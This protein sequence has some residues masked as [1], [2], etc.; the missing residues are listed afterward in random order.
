MQRGL[1][2]GVVVVLIGLCVGAQAAFAAQLHVR[3]DG[4]DSACAGTLDAAAQGASGNACAFRTIQKAV[5]TLSGPGDRVT[6]HAGSYPEYVQIG[7]SHPNG[8]EQAPIVIEGDPNVP[9]SDVV[10]DGSGFDGAMLVNGSGGG[11]TKIYYVFQHFSFK[12]GRLQGIEIGTFVAGYAALCVIRDIEVHS[13]NFVQSTPYNSRV[14]TA[15]TWANGPYGGTGNMLVENVIVDNANNGGAIAPGVG[16]FMTANDSILRNTDIR[17]LRGLGRMGSGATVEFNRMVF[18]DCHSDD[19]CVQLYNTSG[20]VFRYNTI[21]VTGNLWIPNYRFIGIRGINNPYASAV[22]EDNVFEYQGT[23][24]PAFAIVLDQGTQYA[25]IK[26]NVFIGFNNQATSGV[27]GMSGCPDF[28]FTHNALYDSFRTRMDQVPACFQSLDPTNLADTSTIDFD[29]QTYVPDPGSRLVDAG[30]PT[31]S[32]PRNGGT[33]RDVGTYET[34]AG[35]QFPYEFELRDDIDPGIARLDWGNNSAD[36]VNL[37]PPFG[38]STQ[39]GYQCQIDTAPT[40]D[41]QGRG[42]PLFDSGPLG[43][44][45]SADSYCDSSLELP[46]GTYYARVRFGNELAAAQG[47]PGVWS[48][49]YYRF[50]VGGVTLGTGGGGAGGSSGA[51]GPTGAGGGDSGS[52]GSGLDDVG[53]GGCGCRLA[54]APR[55]GAELAYLAIFAAW[56]LFGSW[57]RRRRQSRRRSN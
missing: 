40:F 18:S 31:L 54:A 3:T 1:V 56:A 8:T 47:N 53:R 2:I 51:G 46:N 52:G 39:N 27:L 16:V 6:I 42:V 48:D 20:L 49:H 21:T 43:N 57:L 23:T 14:I 34:G 28:E 44:N 15:S 7:A 37:V 50:S 24:Q 38:F 11:S 36:N 45:Q 25:S 30:D 17:H 33:V 26:N 9:I 10:I 55:R 41:S 5:D 32:I 19:G 22:I 4:S 13:I 12:T 29:P 35:T